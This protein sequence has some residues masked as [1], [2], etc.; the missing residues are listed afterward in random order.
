MP[1]K[2]RN[3]NHGVTVRITPPNSRKIKHIT[4]KTHR[5]FS[6][7]VNLAVE[8]YASNKIVKFTDNGK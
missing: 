4:D 3:V 2:I 7:E 5:T 1:Q 8:E 6:T